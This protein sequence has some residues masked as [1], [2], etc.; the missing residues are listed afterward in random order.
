MCLLNNHNHLTAFTYFPITVMDNW[1][2]IHNRANDF[3]LII[4]SG[5]CFV[6]LART[7]ISK[8]VWNLGL[9]DPRKSFHTQAVGNGH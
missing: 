5:F 3:S 6:H 1:S 4:K 8:P 2:A 7:A 9:S